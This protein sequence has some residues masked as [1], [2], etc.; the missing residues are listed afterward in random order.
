MSKYQVAVLG[1]GPGGYEAAIRCAQ[2]GLKTALI[3][4]RELGGTCLNR[5]CI[6]TK[7]LLHGA[8]VYEN[9]K[10]AAAYGVSTGE[11]S[12]DYA[13]MAAKK[14]QIVSRLRRGIES[15]ER[16]NKVDVIAGFGKLTGKNT[17]DVGGT[18]VEADKIIL[19]MGS[20]PA[21]PPIPG[22]DGKNVLT[23]DDILS[24]T[25]C[26]DS[27]VIIGGGVIGMEFAT[28][29]ATL[30]KKVTVL[31]MMPSILPGVDADIV[32]MLSA[33]LKKKGVTIVNG[34]KVTAIH[35]GD[36]V[37]V[38]YE[39]NGAVNTATGAACVVS[40]GRSPMTRD[41][42]LEELGIAMNRGFVQV[43][44]KL[45]TNVPGI[46]AIGDITGKIQLAHVASAQGLVAA[47]GCAGKAETMSYDIVPSCIYTSPEIAFVGKSEEKAKEAGYDVEIGTFSVAGNGK[48][49]VMGATFGTVKLVTDKA[50]GEILGAQILAPRATDMIAEICAVM[51]CEG[52]IE[53]LAGTIHPHP[54]VSEVI[55]EAAHDVE[56]LCCHAMPKKK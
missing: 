13:K 18:V 34:A 16:G 56:G 38:D 55:M 26:P 27:F 21:C 9:A 43:D 24:M 19:A 50:T 8:E 30:G 22:I 33:D 17:I 14:D 45:E 36:T 3:E 1:G 54:T 4:Y 40:V 5:G 29:F 31:E 49:M 28:L 47:A 11:V 25:D 44:D 20:K 23:S 53:E 52:T 35:G 39:L 6:P 12:F 51:K 48:A 41:C 7:A 42:G 37:S 46:Y 10:E 15:L 2:L 32:A